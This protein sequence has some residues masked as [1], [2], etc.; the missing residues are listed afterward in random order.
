MWGMTLVRRLIFAMKGGFGE[1]KNG[2]IDDV[3]TTPRGD[4]K[5]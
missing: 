4:L 3:S 2:G 5:V 1:Q